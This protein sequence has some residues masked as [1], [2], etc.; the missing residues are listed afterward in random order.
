MELPHKNRKQHPIR[1]ELR[2]CIVIKIET[3]RCSK[4]TG[5]FAYGQLK[6]AV[7]YNNPESL[8]CDFIALSAS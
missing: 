4:D 6:N 2:V 7:K 8:S 5:Y 3:V 1:N